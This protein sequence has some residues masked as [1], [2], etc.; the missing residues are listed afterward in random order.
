MQ[1]RLWTTNVQN[2]EQNTNE[3]ERIR[4]FTNECEYDYE[5]NNVWNYKRNTNDYEIF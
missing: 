2:N 3:Y 5:Q 4:M 1:I